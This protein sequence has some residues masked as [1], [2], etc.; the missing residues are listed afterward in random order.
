MELVHITSAPFPQGRSQL[1]SYPCL[2]G[3]PGRR[4]EH[5]FCGRASSSCTEHKKSIQCRCWHSVSI[6]QGS[7]WYCEHHCYC[8][9]F[10]LQGM[11]YAQ[12][13]LHS[14]CWSLQAPKADAQR[15]LQ[16]LGVQLVD[17]KP[18]LA[19]AR[20]S[21]EGRGK[22]CGKSLPQ[23]PAQCLPAFD[24]A[25]PTQ[26]LR[27]PSLPYTQLLLLCEP[28]GRLYGASEKPGTCPRLWGKFVSLYS[29]HSK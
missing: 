15:R 20:Q 12:M 18:Q 11:F 24:N 23:I 1:C 7:C 16:S 2:W 13:G 28:Q 5:R 22:L 9:M 4:D 19:T 25:F 10:S 17:N 21:V 29:C 27:Q 8:Y 14:L 6:Q 3:R 26:H